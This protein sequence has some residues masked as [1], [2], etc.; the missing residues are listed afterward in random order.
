MIDNKQTFEEMTEDALVNVDDTLAKSEDVEEVSNP[1]MLDE[2]LK[3]DGCMSDNTGVYFHFKP[4]FQTIGADH[5]ESMQTDNDTY[6]WASRNPDKKLE[7]NC[8]WAN[9]TADGF[10]KARGF[11][12]DFLLDI[13]DEK[14]LKALNKKVSFSGQK[15]GNPASKNTYVKF[16]EHVTDLISN[17]SCLD[18]FK[19]AD[20][21]FPEPED[22]ETSEDVEADAL[23]QCFEDY[24]EKTQR[25]A[26]KII[27]DGNL[28]EEIQKSVSLTHAGHH[29]TRDA[30][31]L[32]ETS[33]FVDDG[34]HGL[35][36]GESGDGK[37]DIVL[38]CAENIPARYVHVISSNSPKHI[39]YGFDDYDDEFN[40]IIF[41]DIVL[42]DEIIKLSKL[43]TDNRVKTKVHSTVLNGEPVK[44]TLKGKYIVIMTY[45][46]DMSDEELANRLFNIGVNLVDE[47]DS[48]EKVKAQI[49]DNRVI[50]SDEN[51]LIQGIREPIRAGLQYLIEQDAKIHNPFLS[52]FDPF[53]LNNRD[54]NHLVSMTNARTFFEQNRREQI[55]IDEDT[56][57]TI[58]SLED[59]T[60]T[61]NIW[62]RDE[63]AQLYKLSELQKR[64]IDILPELT[65]EEAFKEVEKLNKKLREAESK[66]TKKKLMEDAP[67]L[68][69]LAKK[70]QCN[71]STLKNSLDRFYGGNKKSL[72]E[73]G[74]ADKIQLDE[75]NPKSP[76]FYFKVK[77][78]GATLN[79]TSLDVHDV[80][81]VFRHVFQSSIVKQLIII[82]LL[83]YVNIILN[84][85][86]ERVVK[87]Y[88]KEFDVEHTADDYNL[89]ID[90]LQ[91]FFNTFDSEQHAIAIADASRED[92]LNMFEFKET[93]ESD[94]KKNDTL[95]EDLEISKN[96]PNSKQTEN[97]RNSKQDD[98]QNV[99]QN[100]TSLAIFKTEIKEFLEEKDI[101]VEIASMTYEYLQAHEDGT[102]QDI[103]NYI[104]GTVNP[105]DF[106]ADITPLKIKR[107][108]YRMYMNDVVDFNEPLYN[109]TSEF[110]DRVKASEVNTC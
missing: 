53:N 100:Q 38:T 34:A 39:F 41:D 45:A 106:N 5:P 92:M 65:L 57:L 71:P 49:R 102:L 72:C 17:S 6:F 59:L 4:Y 35:L 99:N 82:K 21:I 40:I 3:R 69:S 2:A 31:I 54:I 46:K 105:E 36:G 30:L 87:K 109:L 88:C 23:P 56:V 86:G 85:R 22:E 27:N 103:T 16:V 24:P 10:T 52:V 37:T 77:D 93:L 97:T 66:A 108:V 78:D 50:K 67:L 7:I 1:Y 91:G 11:N 98:L 28:F 25:E 19:E 94:I 58:G 96:S 12:I 79:S 43:L 74:L 84:E 60:Y 48:K 8:K 14:D 63:E 18:V 68:K 61:Y 89:I 55:R 47:D 70:L 101:D 95:A 81:T 64:C 13:G 83:I 73:M 110:L 42:N 75:E 80:Q 107:E 76:N 9:K 29:I 62:A 90:F 26:L 44:Y 32:M 15:N 104:C 33:V 20:F 51:K